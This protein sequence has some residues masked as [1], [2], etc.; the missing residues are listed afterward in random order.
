MDWLTLFRWISFVIGAGCLTGLV[1]VQPDE[2]RRFR[3][4]LVDWWAAVTQTG[5][6]WVDKHVLLTRA[7]A[8]KLLV[9]VRLI[10]GSRVPSWAFVLGSTFMSTLGLFA[11]SIDLSAISLKHNIALRG[12]IFV[13]LLLLIALMAAKTKTP[14][15]VLAGSTLGL[16]VA[17]R[18]ENGQMELW[19]F[20]AAAGLVR[21]LILLPLNRLVLHFFSRSRSFAQTLALWPLV[22]VVSTTIGVA[23]AEPAHHG[24][25]AIGETSV[26]GAVINLSVL[27]LCFVNVPL[28]VVSI[29]TVLALA[30]DAVIWSVLQRVLST[31]HDRGPSRDHIRWIG[32]LLVGLAIAPSPFAYVSDKLG[33][34]RPASAA[35]TVQPQ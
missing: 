30:L 4:R 6:T 25:A 2:E 8:A 3:N 19:V 12:S 9:A 14:W 31:L 15:L 28:I 27:L 1:L 35:E 33:F 22:A 5:E 20:V 11:F 34:V 29:G 24:V 17:G 23:L 13:F 32:V 26:V 7:L 10:F 16:V 18:R 21:D